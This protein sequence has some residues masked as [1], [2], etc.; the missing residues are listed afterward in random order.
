MGLTGCVGRV[1]KLFDVMASGQLRGTE[2]C[3]GA[4]RNLGLAF[5][6]RYPEALWIN[7]DTIVATPIPSQVH[8]FGLPKSL[9]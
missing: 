5:G 2:R 8:G 6:C 9:C 7:I 3:R 1:I 4:D